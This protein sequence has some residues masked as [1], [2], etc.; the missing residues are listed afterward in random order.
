MPKHTKHPKNEHVPAMRG[1][2]QAVEERWRIHVGDAPP[3]DR[4]V[5]TRESDRSAVAQRAI[6]RERQVAV[7][8]EVETGHARNVFIFGVFGVLRH[9]L[10]SC[11]L[12]A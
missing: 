10:S 2:E 9:Q 7:C 4:S 8:A 6:A 1:V 11:R 12:R 5:G 3:V